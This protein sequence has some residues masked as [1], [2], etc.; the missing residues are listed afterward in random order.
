METFHIYEA[1]KG[2]VDVVHEMP[3]GKPIG[4]DFPREYLEECGYERRETIGRQEDGKYI[5][6]FRAAPE[7]K[8][9]LY[10]YFIAISDFDFEEY[11]LLKGYGDYLDFL[12]QYLPVFKLMNTFSVDMTGYE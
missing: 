7:C 3:G 5:E 8:A 6:S 10:K 11:V 12:K 4:D 2:F 9:L 1:G